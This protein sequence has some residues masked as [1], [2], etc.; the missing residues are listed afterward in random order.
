[1]EPREGAQREGHEEDPQRVQAD[2]EGTGHHTH[3]HAHR[4]GSLVRRPFAPLPAADPIAVPRGLLLGGEG[5]VL[6]TVEAVTGRA[7]LRIEG[8]GH[9]DQL[10]ERIELAVAVER[11][12]GRLPLDSQPN[13]RQL[14]QRVAQLA[15]EPLLDGLGVVALDRNSSENSS[16]SE[17]M[18]PVFSTT[19]P[20][21]IGSGR[22]VKRGCFLPPSLHSTVTWFAIE[23]ASASRTA[24]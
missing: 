1:M 2:V 7:L 17:K 9:A 15:G 8:V 10:V 24:T 21:T 6:F 3:R 13:V 14:E 12:R 22:Q 16:S 5:L 18:I 11:Q 19:R 4:L 23:V 20:S